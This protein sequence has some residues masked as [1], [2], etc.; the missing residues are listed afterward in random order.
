MPDKRVMQVFQVRT[1]QGVSR[2]K[3]DNQEQ[4]ANQGQQGLQV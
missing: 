3:V 1:E 2:V 4:T